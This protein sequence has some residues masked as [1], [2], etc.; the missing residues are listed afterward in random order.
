MARETI[1]PVTPAEIEFALTR[2]ESVAESL[3]TLDAWFKANP[4]VEEL[5]VWR[6]FSLNDGL[7]RLEA[8]V[9]EIRRAIHAHA[10]GNP[11]NSMSSKARS[12]KKVVDDKLAQADR[13]IAAS[14][15]RAKPKE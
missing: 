11:Q 14:K 2:V 8:V 9:P 15:K 1:G 6:S 4:S 12:S 13:A 10:T 5:W 3:R 7:K